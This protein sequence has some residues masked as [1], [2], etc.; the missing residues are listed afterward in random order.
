MRTI[1]FSVL[2]DDGVSFDAGS[3]RDA[4]EK[5]L[6]TMWTCRNFTLN[7][8]E[9]REVPLTNGLLCLSRMRDESLMI[10]DD[11]EVMVVDIRGDKVRLG[12]RAPG[13][14][15][16]RKEIRTEKERMGRVR[17]DSYVRQGK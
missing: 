10:G 6:A 15:I 14:E 3:V 8:K 12:V 16:D 7:I 2:L 17:R 13:M 4:L 1:H 11:V 9:P 5:A